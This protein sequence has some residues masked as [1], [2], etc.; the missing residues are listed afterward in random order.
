MKNDK[1]RLID[2]IEAKVTYPPMMIMFGVIVFPVGIMLLIDWLVSMFGSIPVQVS[3]SFLDLAAENEKPLLVAVLCEKNARL[4][5]FDLWR[6]RNK[7]L[8]AEAERVEAKAIQS[9]KAACG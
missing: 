9:I 3:A 2:A 6:L 7:I 8:A 4:K 1:Q 5:G